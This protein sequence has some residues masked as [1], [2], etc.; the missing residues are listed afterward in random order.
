MNS[1][2][3]HTLYAYAAHTHT[4]TFNTH[5]D[6]REFLHNFLFFYFL[7][8]MRCG[9]LFRFLVSLSLAAIAM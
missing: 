7:S 5:T 6:N 8:A 2:H 9:F 4:H 3:I 1:I